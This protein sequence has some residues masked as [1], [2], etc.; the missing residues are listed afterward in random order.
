[1]NRLNLCRKGASCFTA[2]WICAC[3]AI[4]VVCLIKARPSHPAKATASNTTRTVSLIASEQ[5][6]AVTKPIQDIR[7]GQRVMAINP[8]R[9]NVEPLLEEPNP[10]NWRHLQLVMDKGNGRQLHIEL[11]RPLSWIETFGAASVEVCA[12]SDPNGTSAFVARTYGEARSGATRADSRAHRTR[13][14]AR[15]SVGGEHMTDAGAHGWRESSQS[16]GFQS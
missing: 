4:T 8:D 3:L 6:P 1:M 5:H 2:L 16:H 11:L 13:D 9:K 7:V 14:A 10:D 12:G 15:A